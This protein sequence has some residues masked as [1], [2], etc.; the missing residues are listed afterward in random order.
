MRFRS[1]SKSTSLLISGDVGPGF[2][3]LGEKSVFANTQRPTR[4][5]HAQKHNRTNARHK[6]KNPRREKRP[7]SHNYVVGRPQT[8]TSTSACKFGQGE[9]ADHHARLRLLWSTARLHGQ[10]G[11]LQLL[12]IGWEEV[13]ARLSEHYNSLDARTKCLL[14]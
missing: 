6:Q 11:G 5:H 14:Y 3:N 2:A 10:R 13:D 9:R 1:V 8:S 7:S 4:S 12:K